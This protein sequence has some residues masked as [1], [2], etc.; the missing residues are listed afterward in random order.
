MLINHLFTLS[1]S[2]ALA[3]ACAEHDNIVPHASLDRR[4]LRTIPQSRDHDWTY[5]AS[6]DWHLI[7]ESR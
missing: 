1:V 7:N 3:A 2:I 5:E 6:Y 4:Q